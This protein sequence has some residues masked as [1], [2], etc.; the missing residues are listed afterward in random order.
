MKTIK[1]SVLRCHIR[2]KNTNDVLFIHTDFALTIKLI[3]LLNSQGNKCAETQGKIKYDG[4][5]ECP[6]FSGRYARPE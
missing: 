5:E 2:G 4:E 1:L 3:H 6:K